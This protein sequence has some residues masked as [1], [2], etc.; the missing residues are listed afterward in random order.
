MTTAAQLITA[1]MQE[2]LVQ[3]SEAPLEA[4]EYND[5]IFALNNMMADYD[6]MSIDLGYTV[7]ANLGDDITVPNG[8]IQPIVK[9]LAIKLAPQFDV[10]VS[11]DLMQQAREGIRTLRRITRKFPVTRMPSTLPYGSG[12]YHDTVNQRHFYP[13]KQPD[14]LGEVSG[15][16]E[17]E[18]NTDAG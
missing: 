5:A 3:A 10:V 7:V 9:N 17:L 14:I 11:G 15:S 13:D 12:N 18:D 6:A 4:D 1:S 8:A 16:I 2:I